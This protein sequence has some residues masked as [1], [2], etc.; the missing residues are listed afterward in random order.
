MKCPKCCAEMAR[1]QFLGIELDRCT[2]C[3]GL[4]FDM[5][6]HEQLKQ[7]AGSESIDTGSADTGRRQ[8]SN[9]SIPCPVCN[10]PL[11]RMV[12]S[13]QPHIWYEGCTVCYGVYFDAGEFKDFKE[14]TFVERV[15]AL[16]SKPRPATPYA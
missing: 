14:L 5:L 13:G 9:A 15:K 6:E 7:L 8:N 10:V 4:W 11:I 2:G 16:V 12:V 1:V 3:Q